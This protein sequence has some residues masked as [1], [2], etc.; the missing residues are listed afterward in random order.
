M[1]VEYLNLIIDTGKPKQ[2][3]GRIKQWL[4]FL[5]QQYEECAALFLRIKKLKDPQEVFR[6]VYS[7]S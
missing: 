7:A 1:I 5:A 2:I 4:G 3:A 6:L